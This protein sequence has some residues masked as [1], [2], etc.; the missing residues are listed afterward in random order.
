MK[1]C[2]KC[3]EEKPMDNFRSGHTVHRGKPIFRTAALCKKC[4]CI[5]TTEYRKKI[6]HTP[7][8]KKKANEYAAKRRY[9]EKLKIL[10]S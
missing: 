1:T 5:Q 10:M 7:E 9:N 8:Y 3:K 6:R 2:T 4:E